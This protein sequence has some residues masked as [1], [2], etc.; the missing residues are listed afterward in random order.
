MN[1]IKAH[2][3]S[4][5]EKACRHLAANVG[6]TESADNSRI[7]IPQENGKPRI[8]E[9]ELKLMFLELFFFRYNNAELHIIGR[10]TYHGRLQIYRE[11]EKSEA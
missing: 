6:E 7:H 4:L 5:I 1:T 2:L 9:Q 10:N 3:I 11:W 8:S